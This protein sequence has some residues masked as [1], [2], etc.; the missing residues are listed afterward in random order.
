MAGQASSDSSSSLALTCKSAIDDLLIPYF[1]HHTDNPGITLV[2][3]P[4]TGDN[5]SSWRRAMLIALSFKNKL[6]FVDGS[7]PKLDMSDTSP[8]NAWIRNNNVVISWIL[9]SISKEIC[10]S[11]I[12]SD[13]ATDI[14]IDLKDRFQQSN[15]PIIFELRRALLNLHQ[16][17][18]SVSLYFTKLQTLWEEL[19]NYRRVCTCGK[20]TYG[21]VRS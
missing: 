17:Q 2:L 4:L 8:F 6:G 1:L 12:F 18:N 11:V 10:T 13:S 16:D 19:T 7:L 9:N 21:S 5:Y 14:W 20:G 15:G 3:Q